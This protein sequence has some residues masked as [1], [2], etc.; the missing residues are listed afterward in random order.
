MEN[1]K[2][3]LRVFLDSNVIIAGIAFARWPYEVLK[4]GEKNEFRIVLC[5]IVLDEVRKRITAIFPHSL[6]RF[7]DFIINGSYEIIA[8][9]EKQELEKHPKLLR[10]IKD[11][12]I[13]LAAIKA[14]TDYLISSDKHFTDKNSSTEEL[15]K[16]IEVLL[17]GTFLRQVMNWT[18]EKLESIRYRT[19]RDIE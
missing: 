12:P 3:K 5:P 11:R 2:Q 9:P 17:P 14:K 16:H 6:N 8:N 15:R 1:E 7:N 13:A 4:Y 19:W 18:S 10:D